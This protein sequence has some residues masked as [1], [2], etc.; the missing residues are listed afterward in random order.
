MMTLL[1][2]PREIRDQIYQQT[3]HFTDN[4]ILAI[5]PFRSATINILG[6]KI[7][8]LNGNTVPREDQNTFRPRQRGVLSLLQTCSQIYHEARCI[9]LE[10]NAVR[11]HSIRAV[12]YEFQGYWGDLVQYIRHIFIGLDITNEVTKSGSILEGILEL[13]RWR[14][15]SGHLKTIT[16]NPD[17]RPGSLKDILCLTNM[18][19]RRE[20]FHAEGAW[21][22]TMLI[23]AQWRIREAELFAG[24]TRRIEFTSRC[25]PDYYNKRMDPTALV[26]QMHEAAGG[27]LWFDGRLCYKDRLKILNPFKTT[28][29]G[30]KQVA[31]FEPGRADLWTDGLTELE[32]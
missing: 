3:F 20:M 22:I 11:F 27:E 18:H 5:V 25:L 32:E 2:L 23:L 12:P 15:M 16:L 10:R 9:V 8:H 7:G 30:T 17:Y 13:G 29:Y 6:S 1:S 14:Q 19:H 28:C 26:E 4:K 24:V 31:W 21:N